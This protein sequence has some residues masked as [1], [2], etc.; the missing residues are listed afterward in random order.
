MVRGLKRN[1]ILSIVNSFLVDSPLPSNINYWYNGG[2]LLGLFMIIQILTG[3]FLA[4]FYTRDISLAFESVEYILRDVNKGWSIRYIHSNGASII[5]IFLYLHIGRGLYYGSFSYPRVIVWSTG[6]VIFLLIMAVAFL[7][8][9]LPWGQMSYW[10]AQVITSMFESIPVLG[11]GIV[12]VLWGG[13]A[14]DK[15]TLTRFFSLHYLLPFIVVG[16]IL[17][18]LLALHQYGS[19]NRLGVNSNS[20]K[21][22]FHTY[23]I[24]KD[25]WGFILAFL[26][27]GVLVFY[28]RNLLGHP[29]NYIAAN[30]NVTRL[31][32]VREWYFLRFY[33]ILRSVPDKVLGVVLMIGSIFILLLLSLINPSIININLSRLY[34]VTFWLFTG[35]L[36]ILGG[37]G[38]LRV[39]YPWEWFGKVCTTIHFIVILVIFPISGYLDLLVAIS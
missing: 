11:G 18:H 21:I 7:G 12:E 15:P 9:V 31:H 6:V 20:D 14:V 8:Y 38:S 16:L 29:D 23:F 19:G 37:I 39:E 17:V 34:R 35:N 32:I 5:F 1:R 30:R 25:V 10:A 4:M 33:A 24:V 3:V 28:Y 27:M 26:L 22:P 13:Y 36:L 2:S